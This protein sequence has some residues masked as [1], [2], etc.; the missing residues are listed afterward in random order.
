MTNTVVDS[1]GFFKN[2]PL[3][4]TPVSVNPVTCVYEL[5]KDAMGVETNIME[6]FN[7]AIEKIWETSR[8]RPQYAFMNKNI[9]KEFVRYIGES[10][11]Y[12]YYT[13]YREA[14]TPREITSFTN[15]ITADSIAIRINNSLPDNVCIFTSVM[16]DR[17]LKTYGDNMYEFQ[18]W[19]VYSSSGL[20]NITN[21]YVYIDKELS[22]VY[23]DTWKEGGEDCVDI[24]TPGETCVLFYE[25]W[26]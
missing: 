24:H 3:D 8:G 5:V 15:Y 6:V 2:W 20:M 21:V 23:I 18:S 10:G 16:A 1:N 9:Y 13:K 14:E 12:A 7:T 11:K 25:E 22:D 19:G 4:S 26:K 17:I